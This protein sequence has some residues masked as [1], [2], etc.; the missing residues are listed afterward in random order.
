MPANGIIDPALRDDVRREVERMDGADRVKLSPNRAHTEVLEN[1]HARATAREFTFE[2][3]EPAWKVGGEDR[4]PRPLE[5]FLAGFNLCQQAIYV[6]NA[7]KDGVELTSLAIDVSGDVDPRGTLGLGDVPPGFVDDTV[8][9]TTHI[10]TPEDRDTMRDFVA[11][12]EHH[13]PAHA[14]LR[15][16][17]AF[18]RT[19]VVNGEELDLGA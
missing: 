3:D 16:P 15:V 6:E 8:A 10:E 5:Y 4:G 7:L 1:F 2:S 12:A 17:M 11:R 18:D 13:C 19:V 14:T 9:Y